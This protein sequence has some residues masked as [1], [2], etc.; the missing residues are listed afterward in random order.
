MELEE[1]NKRFREALKLR[2]KSNPQWNQSKIAQKADISTGYL[3]GILNGN[4]VPSEQVKH[5]LAEACE[6]TVDRLV[7]GEDNVKIT[8]LAP[9]RSQVV[10][11]WKLTPEHIVLLKKAAKVL[12]ATDTTFPNAL[13][14]N[15][16]HFDIGVDAVREGRQRDAG[17]LILNNRKED[18]A[19]ER[20]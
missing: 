5:D 8:Q 15:I 1:K 2:I 3:S 9:G 6:T 10:F 14:E 19:T 18:K 12:L 16:I 20:E 4:K 13:K 11:D 7:Y 17:K